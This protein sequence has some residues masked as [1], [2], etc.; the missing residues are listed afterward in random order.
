MEARARVGNVCLWFVECPNSPQVDKAREQEQLRTPA[1]SAD[2][3][4]DFFAA[5]T[6]ACPLFRL[7]GVEDGPALFDRLARRAILTRPFADNPRWLRIGLPADTI[8]A[9]RLEAALRD[10]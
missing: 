5:P 1:P 8:A 7:L 9:D 10:G 6:G 3:S 4:G 2:V